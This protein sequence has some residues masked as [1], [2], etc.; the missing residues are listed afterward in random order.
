MGEVWITA[1]RA[2]RDRAG[3]EK[4]MLL[5]TW[6]DLADAQG[7]VGKRLRRAFCWRRQREPSELSEPSTIGLDHLRPNSV[8]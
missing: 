5:V 6:L 8:A 1:L 3:A 2:P 7:I 4:E